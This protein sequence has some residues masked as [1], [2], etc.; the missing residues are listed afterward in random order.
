MEWE[1]YRQRQRVVAL[2]YS[3]I[4]WMKPKYSLNASDGEADKWLE[5]WLKCDN[6]A[7][8]RFGL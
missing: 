5:Y 7:V 4:V 2:Y 3:Y 1:D 8:F 6:D